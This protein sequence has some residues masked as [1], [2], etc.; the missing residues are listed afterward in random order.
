MVIVDLGLPAGFDPLPG[1]FEA[2]QQQGL[3]ERHARAGRQVVL[4]LRA[5]RSDRPLTFPYQLQAR[6]PVRVQAPGS[7][8]DNYDEPEVSAESSPVQLTVL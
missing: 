8:F 4:Y 1:T 7:R 3:I 2:L 6:H 5:L